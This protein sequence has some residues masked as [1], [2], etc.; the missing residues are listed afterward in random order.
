MIEFARMRVLAGLAILVCLQGPGCNKADKLE[1]EATANELIVDNEL[2]AQELL[3][4]NEVISSNRGFAM[5]LYR[6]LARE[7]P[8]RNV[9]V[10]PYSVS[11]A[12]ALAVEGARRETAVQMGTVLHYSDSVRQI[13]A[14]AELNPW[15][16]DVIHA[17]MS[18]LNQ[19]FRS[20]PIPQELR[21]RIVTLRK[22]LEEANQQVT[23]LV[24]SRKPGLRDAYP[25]AV[26]AAN[27]L[28][29]LLAQVDQYEVRV[30]NAMWGEQTYPF[31]KSYLATMRKYYGESAVVSVDF[32]SN[33]ESTRQQINAWVE[34]QTNKRIRDLIPSGGV[35]NAQLVLTNAIYFKGEWQQPFLEQKTQLDAFKI[36]DGTTVQVP[37]M[38][39]QYKWDVRY[40]AFTSDLSFFSTPT[41]VPA[42]RDPDPTTVYPGKNGYLM[43]E[44]PYKGG[45]LSMVAVL[46]QQL[47][48]LAVLEKQLTGDMLESWMKT[49]DSRAV[50]VYVP[51]FTL[52]TDYSMKDTLIAMGMPRAFA[53]PRSAEGAQFEGMSE[54]ADPDK[55]LF[56]TDVLHKAFIEVNETGTE[57]A[58]ATALPAG[59]SDGSFGEPTVPFTPTFRADQPFLFLIRDLKTGTILFLG[60]MV[61]PTESSL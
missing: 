23:E 57:A 35:D 49:L 20:K 43:L 30:A 8:G 15:K 32:V 34:E 9:F 56:I 7:N 16:M 12:L 60:R 28:N 10:S 4:A 5:D 52:Q 58:A 14:D 25:K 53:D 50:H 27:E 2:T 51:K 1:V 33:A 54:S 48:G 31:D 13:E 36:P 24:E 6:E 3:T 40:A 19:R 38:H 21:N 39:Q 17:G 26:K 45:D 59:V 41:E 11:S 29:A 47:D 44:I 46:P 18:V 61:H 42:G 37:L 22:D 55:S